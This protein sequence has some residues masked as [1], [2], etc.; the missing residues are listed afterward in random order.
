MRKQFK[1]VCHYFWLQ[2]KMGRECSAQA[3]PIPGRQWNLDPKM[4]FENTG[5]GPQELVEDSWKAIVLHSW[6]HCL[7]MSSGR[8]LNF[9]PSV[10][11]C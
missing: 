1:C 4:L 9:G 10:C 3:Q 6:R 11:I 8:L 7:R 5:L 2:D